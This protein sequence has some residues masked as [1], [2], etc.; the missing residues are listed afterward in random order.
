[1]FV[2]ESAGILVE[3]YPGEGY[4]K[5]IEQM[6]EELPSESLRLLHDKITSSEMPRI[7]RALSN[8]DSNFDEIKSRVNWHNNTLYGAWFYSKFANNNRDARS[9]ARNA[10]SQASAE[11][12]LPIVLSKSGGVSR[13]YGGEWCCDFNVISDDSG[14]PNIRKMAQLI[15]SDD[16]Y[17]EML[18]ELWTKRSNKIVKHE[19]SEEE[20]RVNIAE[21]NNVLAALNK[22]S[23]APMTKKDWE[24]FNS[25]TI[26]RQLG[27]LDKLS[28]DKLNSRKHA[29]LLM[30]AKK[31][32]GGIS[33]NI[34]FG[35]EE[36]NVSRV[37][38]FLRRCGIAVPNAYSYRELGN[39]I[40]TILHEVKEYFRDELEVLEQ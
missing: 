17:W 15:A 22:I 2:L 26:S 38:S 19:P 37:R 31:C 33:D 40:L 27:T 32:R 10:F 35:D 20:K 9:Y 16:K 28:D 3:E 34:D 24:R 7:A 25:S 8:A 36:V 6:L 18:D 11:T 30:M 14:R 29:I 4:K 39:N 23:R 13:R 21:D 12:G 5:P 1:M